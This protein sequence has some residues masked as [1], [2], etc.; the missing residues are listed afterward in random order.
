MRFGRALCVSFVILLLFE[1]RNAKRINSL[2]NASLLL[3]WL[4]VLSKTCVLIST[5]DFIKHIKQAYMQTI[6][7][8]S[9]IGI[10]LLI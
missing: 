6:F 3:F 5:Y 10:G 9:G 2:V 7:T 1:V 4:V 8:D